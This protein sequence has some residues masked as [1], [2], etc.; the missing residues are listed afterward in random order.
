MINLAL[1]GSRIKELRIKKGLTQGEFAKILSVSFQ[2][3]SNWERG[4]A[5]PDI[6]NL[7]NISSYFG[8]LVDTLLS[9]VNEDLYLGVDGGGTKTEFVLTTASGK[10][11]KRTLR[12]GCNP[13]DIGLD[14]TEKIITSG[15]N[16]V[17]TEFPSLKSIFCG[18]SGI[19]TGNYKE[20]LFSSLKKSYPQVKIKIQSDAFNLF[21]IYNKAEMALISGT[22]SVV[23]V[24][25]GEE[26]KRL[27]GWG[28]LFDSLGSAYDIGRAAIISA[29]SEDDNL[30][31]PS[32]INLML[33]KK[34][35]VSRIWEHIDSFY[36]G[37]KSYIASF[38]SLVFEAYAEG[39]DK[40]IQIIDENAKA[41]AELLNKA[42]NL[43]GIKP[44]AVASGG[45]FEHFSDILINHI[46]RYTE[47]KL[48]VSDLPPIY[49]ACRKAREASPFTESD[50]FYQNFKK[51]YEESIVK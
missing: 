31:E 10:V 33:R 11:L 26:Y 49:G 8:V 6:E 14:E 28:H 3:V 37:G 25:T 15:I 35:N 43:Y 44:V 1:L 40:A 21:G 48:L 27:G 5:P 38:A 19:S 13:N 9:P 22:G 47:V 41:L 39:D 23:F 29:L 51:T 16:A 17:L 46:K 50:I 34:V 32:L 18:I 30:E 45:L 36:R 42:V 7:M 20:K 4:V 2:A 12:G 24:K